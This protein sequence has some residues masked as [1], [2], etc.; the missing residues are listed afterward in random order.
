MSL[1]YSILFLTI[2]CTLSYFPA[3]WILP[4]PKSDKFTELQMKKRL[5][6][7]DIPRG[8]RTLQVVR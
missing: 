3:K 2:V 6:N 7:D 8:G 5:L 1:A 4:L